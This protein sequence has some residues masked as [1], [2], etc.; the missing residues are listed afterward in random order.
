MS[1][2]A[3]AETLIETAG[4]SEDAVNEPRS[5]YHSGLTIDN[6]PQDTNVTPNKQHKMNH[7]LQALVGSLNWL[8]ITTRPDIAPITNFLA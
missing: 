8:A 4:L 5:P 2:E 3:F 7:L 6:I 1:Q